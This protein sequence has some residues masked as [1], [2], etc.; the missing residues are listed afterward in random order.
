MQKRRK[1]TIVGPEST[2]KSALA[3]Y[4]SEKLNGCLVDEAARKY[5]DNLKRP[6]IEEDLL[7]IA[8]LQQSEE[9]KCSAEKGKPFIICDTN[10]LVIKIW[11]L[12]KYQRCHPC[13]PAHL[14]KSSQMP[15]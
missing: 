8:R 1:I 12:H 4:L 5:I 2:G 15:G 7:A 6:Y 3:N 11:S 13:V 9:E 14:P 10:L